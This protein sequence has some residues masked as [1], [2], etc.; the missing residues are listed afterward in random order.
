MHFVLTYDLSATGERRAEIER[1]ID[2]VLHPYRHTRH[3]TTFYII[4]VDTRQQWVDIRNQLQNLAR[5][6]SEIFHFIMSPT[7]SGGVYDGFL[8]TTEWEDINSITNL[9]QSNVH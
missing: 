4:H 6:I 1:Q 2:D 8:I 5:S 7:M 9:D 3:L